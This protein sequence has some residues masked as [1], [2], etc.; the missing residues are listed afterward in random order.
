[1]EEVRRIA[2]AHIAG[3]KELVRSHPTGC[4]PL[5]SAHLTSAIGEVVA[6]VKRNDLSAVTSPA[7]MPLADT[8]CYNSRYYEGIV[9]DDSLCFAA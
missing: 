8:L 4:L 1:V 7:F 3:K 5:P 9:K 6:N 2:F